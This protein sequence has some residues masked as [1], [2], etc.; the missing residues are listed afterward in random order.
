M[1]TKTALGVG[2]ALVVAIGAGWL[3]GSAGRRPAEQALRVATLQQELLEGHAA[4]LGARLD[5]YSVNFGEASRHFEAARTSLTRAI[6]YL[7]S[8]D[9]DE[10]AARIQGMMAGLDDA[11]R[12]AGNLDQNANSRAAEVAKVVAEVIAAGPAAAAPK[13]P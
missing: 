7:K 10:D 1:T 12:L 6:D 4:L 13:R 2:I 5:I 3:W 9:R 8:L 11:Q